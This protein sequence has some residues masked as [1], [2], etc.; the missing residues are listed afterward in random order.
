MPV[1]R[2]PDPR[3]RRSRCV[4]RHQVTAGPRVGGEAVEVFVRR[5]VEGGDDEHGEAVRVATS[6]ELARGGP[7]AAAAW[8]RRCPGRRRPRCAGR[9][10]GRCVPSPSPGTGPC[11]RQGELAVG[12]VEHR[13]VVVGCRVG[14]GVADLAELRADPGDLAVRTAGDAAVRQHA[15]PVGLGAEGERV[16]VPVLDHPRAARHEQPGDL[17]P[18]PVVRRTVHRGAP[19]RAGVGLGHQERRLLR[20]VHE[21][22]ELGHGPRPR[23]THPIGRWR[24]AG[25]SGGERVLHLVVGVAAGDVEPCAELLV[26]DRRAARR[27]CRS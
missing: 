13:D 18:L 16:P 19:D 4:A 8:R 15:A 1:R 9:S 26:V 3:R 11:V 17:A 14:E 12:V 7:S 27:R 25:R 21:V 20:G 6:R 10:R 5:R 22:G 23:T 2:G 24:G